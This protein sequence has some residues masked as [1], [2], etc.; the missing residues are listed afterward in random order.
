MKRTKRCIT[1]FIVLNSVFVGA[2]IFLLF[3]FADDLF[4]KELWNTDPSH[5][6]FHIPLYAHVI[7]FMMAIIF[8]SFAACSNPGFAKC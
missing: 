5:L 7:F 2:T 3:R 8:Y 6:Y 1:G 4:P